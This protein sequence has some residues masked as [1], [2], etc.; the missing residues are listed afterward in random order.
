MNAKSLVT[1]S[2]RRVLDNEAIAPWN[3]SS[4]L[5][6]VKSTTAK[7]ILMNH[8]GP[9]SKSRFDSSGHIHLPDQ[10]SIAM[11]E[12]PGFEYARSQVMWFKLS[13]KTVRR[14]V[15]SASSMWISL[16]RHLSESV[17]FQ[18]SAVL[19]QRDDSAKSTDNSSSS[20]SGRARLYKVRGTN[21]EKAEEEEGVEAEDEDEK[22]PPGFVSQGDSKL[23]FLIGSENGS[24]CNASIS[25]DCFKYLSA[26]H[27]T[28]D[29]GKEVA[30]LSIVQGGHICTAITR[31]S[32]FAPRESSLR[33]RTRRVLAST[34]GVQ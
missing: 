19:L 32:L 30:L 2:C 21:E 27:V 1:K 5:E 25:G 22:D 11:K 31:S 9:E 18:E 29:K 3:F 20:S 6:L 34:C 17:C 14:S 4:V 7:A 13:A 10:G 8:L 26:V 33:K 23:Y 12:D 16:L 28:R 15:Q 24:R